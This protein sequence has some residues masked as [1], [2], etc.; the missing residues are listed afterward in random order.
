MKS[1]YQKEW[2][3]LNLSLLSTTDPE[4]NIYE[5]F[6]NK[7]VE[8]ISDYDSVPLEWRAEKDV[9]SNQIFDLITDKKKDPKVLSIGCGL[10]Y[11][12]H[13]L[14]TLCS[15]THL[16]LKLYAVEPFFDPVLSGLLVG[17]E[18]RKNFFRSNDYT[19][20]LDLIYLSSV[21]YVFKD[22]EYIDFLRDINKCS[23]DQ[24]LI[25]EIIYDKNNFLYNLKYMLRK[26]LRIIKVD[27]KSVYWGL[28]RTIDEHKMLI[29]AAGLVIDDCGLLETG[30]YWFRCKKK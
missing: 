19:T 10:G 2:L 17:A 30:T 4:Q 7:L 13:K 14:M 29:R 28:V 27:T 1:L 18:F 6:Y 15:Q 23:F 20:H 8:N 26:L 25:T 21:D 11:V 5:K 3:G 9:L 12:E 24:F 16:K 22:D